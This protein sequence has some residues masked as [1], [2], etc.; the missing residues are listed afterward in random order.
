MR[1]YEELECG[2]LVSEDGGGGLLPCEK[3]I[4]GEA[5]EGDPLNKYFESVRQAVG[6]CGLSN[7]H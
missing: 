5:I 3:H 6:N 2:C 7:T 1:I 4:E